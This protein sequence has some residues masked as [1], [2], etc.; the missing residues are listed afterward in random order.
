[1]TLCINCRVEDIDEEDWNKLKG[2]CKRC[3][4]LAK[5]QPFMSVRRTGRRN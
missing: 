1:M 3:R 2:Q 5:E 4:K